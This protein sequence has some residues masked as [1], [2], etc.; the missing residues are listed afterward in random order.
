MHGARGNTARGRSLLHGARGHK[1]RGRSL[2]H[3]ARGHTAW[4]RSLLHGARGHTARGRSLM[5]GARGRTGSSSIATALWVGCR[6]LYL[7]SAHDVHFA[8]TGLL[9]RLLLRCCCILWMPR[10]ALPA[11]ALLGLVTLM[12]RLLLTA[13]PPHNLE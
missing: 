6:R 10:P 8:P 4:G 5:H 13:C 12:R 11:L 7:T 2:L 3:G 9:L 1:A